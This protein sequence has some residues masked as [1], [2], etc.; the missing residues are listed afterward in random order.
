MWL[1]VTKDIPVSFDLE[2]G[3]GKA[4]LNMT[5]LSVKDLNLSAGASSVLLRFDEPNKSTIEDMSIEAG[6][7][8]FHGY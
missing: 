2:L 8:K 4:D 5:G 3:M 6:L 7:S 1:N